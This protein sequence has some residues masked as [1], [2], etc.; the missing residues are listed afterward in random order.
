MVGC[1][2]FEHHCA[3][4]DAGHNIVRAGEELLGPPIRGFRNDWIEN[5]ERALDM[6][7]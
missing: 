1:A 3:G 4:H 7:E 6:A 5:T 2:A